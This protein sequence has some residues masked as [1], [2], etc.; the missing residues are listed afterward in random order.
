ME[1]KTSL[2]DFLQVLFFRKNI[3]LTL[4]VTIS[5]AAFAAS[6]VA[7]PVF[8]AFA[9]LVIE[10]EPAAPGLL[11]TPQQISSPPLLSA[12]QEAAELA[13]TQS[14]IITSRVVLRKAIEALKLAPSSSEKEIERA[15]GELQ[16]S[17]VVEPVKD[18]MD[19]IKV[20]VQ[21]S[22]P[23][24]AA[25]MANAVSQ[26]Y[27]SWYIERKK[28]KASSTVS[29][30]DKQ[31]T[32]LS[33]QLA[34]GEAQLEALKEEGGLIS[35]E[36]QVGATLNRLSEFEAA[37]QKT[38]GEEEETQTRLN[39]LRGQL[40]NPDA[41]ILETVKPAPHPTVELLKSKLLDLELRLAS[42]TGTYTE[43]SAPV[44]K[45]KR[46]IEEVRKKLQEKMVEASL[47]GLPKDHPIYQ[48]IVKDIISLQTSLEALKV[49]QSFFE[50]VLDE[51][52]LKAT[53]LGEREKE[54]KR[55]NRD[56]EA[57]ENLYTLLQTRREEAAV[58]ESL[59]E[60]GIATVKVL[61]P[62]TPPQKPIKP[63]RVLNSI[64]GCMVGLMMG[65]S[66]ASLFEYFDHSFKSTDDV[67]HFLGLPVLAAVPRVEARSVKRRR[68]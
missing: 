48:G 25:D 67:E 43:E 7:T 23:Q 51:Y 29:F 32:S 24:K 26:A 60:E 16:E 17:V 42:L 55:V 34:E 20:S 4:F 54:Y 53:E 21:N 46:E 41:A 65:V 40:S 6:V 68:K 38:L 2:R 27:V 52:R 66:T 11:Q 50:K 58:S 9:V 62:A 5:L 61:D 12:S 47:E 15:L 45:L 39:K 36:A 33:K 64:L 63:N 30:I 18:T 13:R 1:V 35:V 22:D 44:I 31:L 8:E 37:L 14:E 10:K 3:I 49:R 28:G 59:K 19:L 57:K 56:I